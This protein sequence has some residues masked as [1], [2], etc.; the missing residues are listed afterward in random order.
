MPIG[1]SKR[2]QVTFVDDELQV[3]FNEWMRRYIEEPHRFEVEF[4]SVN[5]YLK[6]I[7]DGVEPSYGESCAFYILKLRDEMTANPV[8]GAAT[9]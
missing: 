5:E 3:I 2:S 7:A 8:T 9:D 6:E 1:I 4:K